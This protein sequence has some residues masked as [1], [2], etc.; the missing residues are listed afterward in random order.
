VLVLF[1]GRLETVTAPAAALALASSVRD[2]FV[3]EVVKG[4]PEPGGGLLP[5]LA[6]GDTR[7]VSEELD[8]AL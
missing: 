1:A 6:V 7:A 5:G 2:G 3:T 8:A 4:L